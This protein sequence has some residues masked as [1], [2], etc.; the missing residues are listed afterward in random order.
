MDDFLALIGLL[1]LLVVVALLAAGGVALAMALRL[2]RKVRELEAA[3]RSLRAPA[4]PEPARAP[5]ALPA[6]PAAP[7]PA[8]EARE[9]PPLPPLPPPP[10]PPSRRLD[11]ESFERLVGTRW[12]SWIGALVTVVGIAFLLKLL[13]DRGWI[14][15]A[16]R[17]GIGLGVSL[18]V[19]LLG[20]LKVRKAHDLLA[21]AV[22]A[23]GLGGLYLTTFLAYSF[24]DFSGRAATFCFLSWF[25]LFTV[26]LS[27]LRRGKLLAV[28]G[29]VSAYATP[30]LLST[31]E[32]Q[33]EVLFSFL[34]LLALAGAGVRVA[35]DWPGV[36][37]LGFAF[38]LLYYAGWHDQFYVPD[39][40]S[41]AVAGAAGLVVFFVLSALARGFWRSSAVRVLDAALLC[42]AQ[43]AGLR[44]LWAV[45][46]ADHAPALGFALAGAALLD[47]GV[48]WAARWRKASSPVLESALLAVAAGSIVLVIPASL[49][50]E[51]AVLAW[52]LAA[53]VLAEIASRSG[54]L[55]IELAAAACLVA[56]PLAGLTQGVKHTGVFLLVANRVFAA[57]IAVPA[58]WFLAGLRAAARPSGPLR[59]A[60][61]IGLEAAAGAMLLALLTYEVVTWFR[62]EI[63]VR[64]ADVRALADARTAS[65]LALWALYPWLW[66]WRAP[67]RPVLWVPGAVCYAVLGVPFIALLGG[68][69]RREALVFLNVSFAAGLLFPAGV[70]AVARGLALGGRAVRTAL[71]M[72]G[73]VLLVLLITFELNTGLSVSDWTPAS[74]RWVRLAVI[75][76]SWAIYAAVLIGWGVRREDAPSRWFGLCLLAATLVKV[77]AVD[78]SEARQVWR[79]LSFV[80]LGAFLMVSSYFYALHARK[81]KAGRGSETTAVR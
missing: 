8:R 71:R 27:V 57:W 36:S 41:I 3:I 68:L 29:L 47:I 65:L 63:G 21:Q 26:A 7:S 69:H 16:G 34:A 80:V 48:L 1:L 28:L 31:G 67:R 10:R 13:Y 79:V 40:L 19:L 66:L 30:Y 18:A 2:R 32:D 60:A 23:T 44:Y 35:R 54:R 56:A 59:R 53:V 78:M 70:F 38:S 58:A 72:Y 51:G 75:S 73:H 39:R 42:V 4:A 61:G 55:P 49:E 14:G 76:V 45:L 46:A 12:L 52:S 15:P 81:T 25:A 33:A 50:A 5:Q 77:L 22:S 74:Q 20:E 43:I 17:V 11:I 6:A 9:A 64:G 62:G 37:L 24:Y